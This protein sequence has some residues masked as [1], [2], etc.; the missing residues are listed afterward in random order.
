[1]RCAI[2]SRYSSDLQNERSIDDQVR[3]CRQY[4]HSTGW[5]V[6]EDHV[7]ED[8]AVSGASTVGRQG[9]QQLLQ[10]ANTR[11]KPFDYVLVDDTSR[12]S[13]DQMDQQNIIRELVYL[14]IHMYFVSQGID[15]RHEQAI[16]V[17]LPVHGI[18]D[19]LYRL[20]LGKKTLRGMAGQVLKGFN[21]GGKTYGYAYTRL[22]DPNGEID[23]KTGHVRFLG[24]RISINAEQA[25]VMAE[26]FK[27][28]SAGWSLKELAKDLN[29]RGVR[30]PGHDTQRRILKVRPSWC[31]NALRFMLQNR[32]YIGDWTWNKTRSMSNPRTGKRRY[33][34]RPREEWVNA[35]YPDLRIVG[36]SDWEKVAERF[37]ANKHKGKRTYGG[38]QNTYLLSGLLHC[39]VC[40]ARYVLVGGGTNPDPLYG[41]SLNW[42]RGRTVCPNSARV[43]KSELESAVIGDLKK[44]LFRKSVLKEIVSCAN[45]KLSSA[46]STHATEIAHLEGDIAECKRA[47]KNLMMAV[48][49]GEVFSRSIQDRLCEKE[50]EL[51]ETETRLALLQ[52]AVQAPKMVIADEFVE[53]WLLRLNKVFE[54]DQVGAKAALRTYLTSI[55]LEPIQED[56]RRLLRASSRPNLVAIFDACGAS[57]GINSG[58]RI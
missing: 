37:Q 12:L 33:E 44:R 3:N 34:E 41:C 20:E 21:P 47:I 9:L 32:K 10:A 29:Q 2:Y 55:E 28:F 52:R 58:G 17:M 27:R 18:A 53:S 5:S 40:G 22:Y 35:I 48:E 31:P 25:A 49:S 30:P 42:N 11:P 45:E 57:K 14:G 43:R 23:R 38:V 15:S 24:T 16:H 1:M 50:T 36:D 19:S 6:L 7:Y 13:R 4:A 54:R 26:I 8:R 56:G 46:R 39:A 51:R